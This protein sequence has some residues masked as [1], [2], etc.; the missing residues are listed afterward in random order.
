MVELRPLPTLFAIKVKNEYRFYSSIKDTIFNKQ[1]NTVTFEDNKNITSFKL[2]KHYNAINL[3]LVKNKNI[4][5]SCKW[6]YTNEILVTE[7]Q[8]EFLVLNLIRCPYI[9]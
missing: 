4:Y 6:G 1:V 2:N 8:E 5:S 9:T 7:K 3:S